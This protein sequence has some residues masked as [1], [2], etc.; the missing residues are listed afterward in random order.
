ML[1]KIIRKYYDAIFDYCYHSVG[2]RSAAED[3]CQDT[4]ASFIEHYADCR[5]AGKIKNYLY[6]IARNKCTDYDRKK[7]PVFMEEVPKEET[8]E[9]ESG[10]ASLLLTTKFGKN[11]LI[12]SKIA[13]LLLFIVGYLS[14]GILAAAFLLTQKGFVKGK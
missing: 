3:L 2:N 7:T 1:E 11:R 8:A 13:A 4:F 5:N 10:A 9:Y 12:W 14:V 6:T